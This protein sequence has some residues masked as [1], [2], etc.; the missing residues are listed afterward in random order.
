MEEELNRVPATY[1]L[2]HSLRGLCI[3]ES[4]LWVYAVFWRIIPRSY[5]QPNWDFQGGTYDKL[6]GFNKYWMLAWE[7]GFCNFVASKDEKNS[8][9]GSSTDNNC[10]TQQFNGLQPEL[11]FKMSHEFYNYGEGLI[12][13]VAADQGHKWV[14]NEDS[15]Q[16]TMFSAWH[17]LEDTHPRTWAAQFQSGIKTIALIAVEEGVLQLGAAQKVTKDIS[18]VLELQKKFSYLHRIPG[19]LLSHPSSAA[20]TSFMTAGIH[21]SSRHCCQN[22]LLLCLQHLQPCFKSMT[23]RLALRRLRIHQ[24]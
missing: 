7:D 1:L 21:N 22:S 14:Y 4:S 12:G 20:I 5:P 18:Y 3:H 15:D 17:L 24:K 13:K 11:F 19:F 10:S 9:E 16:E 23:H 2:Q 6:K 8:K